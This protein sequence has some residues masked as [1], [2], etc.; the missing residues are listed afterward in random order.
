[1]LTVITYGPVALVGMLANLRIMYV[2][3]GELRAATQKTAASSFVLS[4]CLADTFQLAI[5]FAFSLQFQIQK[6][7]LWSGY[8]KLACIFHNS[9]TIINLFVSVLFLMIISVDRFVLVMPCDT[10]QL[11]KRARGHP[12]YVRIVSV[13]VW[14][15]SLFLVARV[16]II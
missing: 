5:S 7:E 1:M 13:C 12:Q 3:I 6:L 10:F 11:L 9:G 15:A 8:G 2:L 14:S 4:L 16:T